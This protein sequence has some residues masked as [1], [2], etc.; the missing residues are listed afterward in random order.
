MVDVAADGPVAIEWGGREYRVGC[1]DLA[2]FEALAHLDLDV[3]AMDRALGSLRQEYRAAA[4]ASAVHA[5]QCC[6]TAGPGVIEQQATLAVRAMQSVVELAIL[7]GT[8]GADPETVK[9]MVRSL[10]ARDL[11]RVVQGVVL[12]MGDQ[13]TRLERLANVQGTV[14][15]A[16]S[17]AVLGHVPGE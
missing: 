9:A 4:I 6:R 17:I 11:W 3:Q 7:R 16:I 8:P 5:M 13:M 1:P 14:C 12:A 10:G 2:D 15:G